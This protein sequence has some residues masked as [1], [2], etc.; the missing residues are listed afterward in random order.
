MADTTLVHN[1]AAYLNPAV[2]LKPTSLTASQNSGATNN[3][4]TIDRFASAG[5]YRSVD[6]VALVR[7]SGSSKFKVTTTLRLQDSANGSS[8][9]SYGS[10]SATPGVT[11]AT[12]AT[13][14]QTLAGAV[15]VGV[16]LGSARRYVR[17]NTILTWGGTNKSTPAQVGVAAILGGSDLIT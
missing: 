5:L 4:A 10:A 6:V 11:G 1:I 8:W 7:A 9:S 12:N 14:K 16:D 17:V 3:G 15:S 2:A 13:G